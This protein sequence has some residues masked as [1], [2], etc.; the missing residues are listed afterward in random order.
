MILQ[1]GVGLTTQYHKRE[2][3]YEMFIRLLC[4][5]G[6]VFHRQFL[7]INLF[8]LIKEIH[9]IVAALATTDST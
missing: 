9:F 2:A 8:L 5:A 6:W 1:L 7:Y 3:C 4:K